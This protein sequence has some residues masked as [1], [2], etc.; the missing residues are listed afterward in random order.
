MVDQVGIC[1]LALS[2]LGAKLITSISDEQIEAVLCKANY[3]PARDAVLEDRDWTF[4]IKRRRLT[5]LADYDEAGFTYA[6]RLPPEVL[7]VITVTDGNNQTDVGRGRDIH[8]QREGQNILANESEI[9]TRTVDI[10]TSE[11]RFMATFVQAFA[12][13]LAADICTPL[14]HSDS[15]QTK[16]WQ[17]YERKLGIAAASDGRQGRSE[18]ITPTELLVSRRLGRGIL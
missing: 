13:R 17:L 6:F 11:V 1:N 18:K 15:L 4:A 5:P 10:I 9:H 8:W 16:M 3:D 2:W 7:R 12:A 14:T